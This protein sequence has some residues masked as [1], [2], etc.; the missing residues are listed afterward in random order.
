MSLEGQY[1]FP[2]PICFYPSKDKHIKYS[3]SCREEFNLPLLDL[4]LLLTIKMLFNLL[5]VVVA[6]A[7]SAVALPSSLDHVVL[8][9]RRDPSSWIPQPNVAL[10]KHF[11]L[12]IKIGLRESSTDNGNQ[13][14]M[15]NADPSSKDY[16]KHM[17][18]EQVSALST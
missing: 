13:I 15:N 7:V 10:D 1:A 17:S 16:G 5:N 12:P 11:S 9:K 14:L 4:N 18:L 2:I 6:C 3:E 8:E